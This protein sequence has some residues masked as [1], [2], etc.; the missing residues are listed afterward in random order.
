[1]ELKNFKEMVAV[2][3]VKQAGRE[4]VSFLLVMWQSRD[5][6]VPVQLVGDAFEEHVLLL[7]NPQL[8]YVTFD[9]HQR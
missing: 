7:D 1:M 5:E 6:C 4:K 8:S 3:L 2:N 9:F